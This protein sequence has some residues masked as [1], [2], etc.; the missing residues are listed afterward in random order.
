MIFVNS[1]LNKKPIQ[2]L[3]LL[4]LYIAGQ[5]PFGYYAYSFEFLGQHT[6]AGVQLWNYVW[7]GVNIYILSVFIFNHR[8]SITK[9]FFTG[10]DRISRKE[11]LKKLK[12]E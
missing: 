8:L 2:T 9:S 12:L 5:L 11:Q 6:L 3:F 7:F 4:F 1:D 10:G